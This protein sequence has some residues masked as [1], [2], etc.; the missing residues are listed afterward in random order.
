[1]S[2][3]SSSPNPKRLKLDLPS[4]LRSLSSLQCDVSP[5]LL[6]EGTASDP[7]AFDRDRDPLTDLPRLAPSESKA[8]QQVVDLTA[9]APG[10]KDLSGSGSKPEAPTPTTALTSSSPFRLTRIRDLPN[11]ENRD[12]VGVEEILGDVMLRA[13]WLFNYMHEIPWVLDQLDEDIKDH[14]E[15]NFVHGNW[16]A[17]DGT[18]L[19]MEACFLALAVLTSQAMAK[20]HPNVRLVAAYM[21]EAFGTHHTKIMVLF[22]ADDTAQVVIHTANMISFDW[23]NMTQAAWISPLLPLAKD[24]QPPSPVGETFKK[25]LLEYFSFYGKARTGRLVDQLR[26]YSFSAVKAIFIGSVPGRHRVSEAKWGWPKLR[27]VLRT[28]PASSPDKRPKIMAQCSSIATLGQNNTWLNP[29]LFSALSATATKDAKKP[30]FGII[31]PT[32]QE[33]RDSLNGYASGSSIHLRT[34]SAQQQKQ[35]SYLKP[36]L[37]HW[38]SADDATRAGRDLAAPHIKTYIRFSEDPA[39]ADTNI[40]W[41]LVTSANLSTQAW[42]AAEKDGTVRICS[43]EAGVLVHPGLWGQGVELKPAFLKDERTQDNGGRVVPLRMPYSLPVRKHDAKEE[44]WCVD[45]QWREVDWLGRS[46]AA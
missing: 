44:V 43:Y 41:A 45:K 15:V 27:K 25:D 31:F 28:I 37:H 3:S 26:K 36:L 7:T 9:D 23:T 20:D 18:R 1:M 46:Y 35:L 32:V 10:A 8:P 2:S 5:P 33:I 40:D 13:V 17:D 39:G 24:S 21:P 12:T 4:P 30:E 29:V 38:S 11:S 42:G 22:R 16:K 19:T 14:V 6:A 34:A